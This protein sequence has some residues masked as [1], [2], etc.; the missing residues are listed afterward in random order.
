M[1]DQML[2]PPEYQA[3]LDAL[4]RKQRMAQMLQQRGL[5]MPMPQQ[6]G[7]VASKVSP[8]A[9]IASALAGG[10][11]GYSDQQATEGLSKVR[12]QYNTDESA[13]VAKL[14][15]MPEGER[16][17]GGLNS[18]FPRSRKLAEE[19][20]K[21]QEKQRELKSGVYKDMGD[22]N[23]ALSV[24]DGGPVGPRVEPKQPVVSMVPGGPNG[25]NIPAVTNFGKWG[26]PTMHLGANGPAE[27]NLTQ[28]TD[29]PKQTSEMATKF[30]GDTLKEKQTKAS[31]A[32]DNLSSINQ[33]V[34]ALESG[35]KAGG[36]EGYMQALRQAAQF[37]NIDTKDISGTTQLEM[38]LG[39]RALD[40]VKNLKPAS[41]TDFKA[42]QKIAGNIGTDPT[43]LVK[44]LAYAQAESLR[45]LQGYNDYVGENQ[46]NIKDPETQA[47]F[48]G[49]GSGFEMPNSFAGPLPYQMEV[50]RN[51]QRN[52]VDIT[53]FK[54]PSGKPFAQDSKFNLDP[55]AGFPG[56]Q[57]PASQGLTPAEQAELE[58]LRKRFSTK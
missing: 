5:N 3:Q 23:N 12:Q 16:V 34:D 27:I 13:D 30:L 32:K 48:L 18:Q 42:A 15:G 20:Q 56:I 50:M 28:K 2:L 1:A 17:A 38:S 47:M 49:A 29:L 8:F 35:A 14:L 10:Y 37:F 54:D 24:L 40:Q 7:S 33:T 39:Q 53:R 57:K 26:Q 11:G 6:S 45:H 58:N 25:K 51:L 4:T 52:G 55:T 46:K 41:D 22:A 9:A 44:V 36:G 43:A 21:M 19:W 31:L